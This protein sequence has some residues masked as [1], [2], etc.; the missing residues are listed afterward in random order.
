MVTK[1]PAFP[2]QAN[3]NN[4]CFIKGS[5]GSN[6]LIIVNEKFNNKVVEAMFDKKDAVE[7]FKIIIVIKI[8]F[9]LR[10]IFDKANAEILSVICNFVKAADIVIEP[11]NKKMIGSI[12]LDVILTA[13]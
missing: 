4:N 8:V 13:I 2:L 9:G 1:P 3:P 10:D 5:S 11:K 12:N 7:K 6:D